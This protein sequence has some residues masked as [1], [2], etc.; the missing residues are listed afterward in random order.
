[1]FTT[2]S[3]SLKALLN[4]VQVGK[5]QLPDF[6]RGWIWDEDRIK[7]LL[8][9]ISRGF[10]VGAIMT[11]SAGGDIR[12]KTRLV[13]GVSDNG[14]SPPDRFLLDGQQRLTSLYQALLHPGPVTTQNSRGEKRPTWFYIDMRR[15]VSEA[16][17]RE[18]AVIS[19]P[20][21]KK[22]TQDF[23]RETTLDL[24]SPEFEYGELMFPTEKLFDPLEWTLNYTEYWVSRAGLHPEGNPT[25][26][27][28]K[29][30]DEVV[31]PFADYLL[32]VIH[33]EK[34]T[35]KEAVCTVFEKV[36]TGGVP[37]NAFELVTASFAAEAEEFSL[38]DDWRAR[39]ER[40]YPS[41]GGV[42][43]G[44]EGEHFLQAIAL[45]KTQEDRRRAIDSGQPA[46][47]LP[48]ISC[49]RRDILNLHLQ[50]YQE[51]SERVEAGFRKAA[52]FL[53]SQFVFGRQNVPYNAQ[54]VPLAALYVELGG[55]LEPALAREKLAHWYWSGIFGEAYGGN[56]E[57]QYALDLNQVAE[58]VREGI[59]PTLIAQANFVP[60]R[61]LTLSTRNSAAY[62]GLYAL[63]MKNGATDWRSN[64]TLS[65]AT[66]NNEN[67]DIHHVFPVAWCQS[68]EG[69]PA[70]SRLLYDSV[71]NKTPLSAA[72]NRIIGG[73]GPAVYLKRL[74]E[75]MGTARL[76]Q[77]LEAHWLN[78]VYLRANSFQDSFVERGETLLRLIGQAMG[79]ELGSGRDV[80]RGA[81]SSAGYSES[82][83]EEEPEYDA[84]GD[85]A[86]NEEGTT[87]A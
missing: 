41:F 24:S 81:L 87:A 33:L 58:Y 78:P 59:E 77:A 63:Q 86:A 76:E 83:Q 56:T 82:F 48:S 10:P 15:A 44:T 47:R 64:V 54:L 60:E 79:R 73:R 67:I 9:S 45:L 1:M 68:T 11:L 52:A 66:Y 23:G 6:Q 36:N 28:K 12:F 50:D 53:Q 46:N 49:K 13:E 51:W 27:L 80:F 39:K 69:K 18:D 40:L 22:V 14:L 72:T 74:E 35:P 21:S 25:E 3:L 65:L 61:L 8:A 26:F 4:D 43:Q 7:G 38:R 55:E 30:N 29:F 2:F 32:P 17:D 5:I 16:A 34:E 71:I 31:K 57:S 84:L 62:K 20:E 70:I 19:V 75:D 42:L 37:L 85:G